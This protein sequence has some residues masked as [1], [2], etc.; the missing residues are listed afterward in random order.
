MKLVN[1]GYNQ[2]P[3]ESVDENEALEAS[4]TTDRNRR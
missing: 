1:H 2:I 3:L 4:E